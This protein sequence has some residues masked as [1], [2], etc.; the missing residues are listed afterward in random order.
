MNAIYVNLEGES[1]Y[2]EEEMV[3]AYHRDVAQLIAD[4]PAAQLLT[5]VEWL[6]ELRDVGLLEVDESG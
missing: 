4:S 2:T 6:D 1:A 5:Y 3:E